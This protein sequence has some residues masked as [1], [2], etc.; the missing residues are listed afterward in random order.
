[1]TD[2]IAF[3]RV[4]DADGNDVS[5]DVLPPLSGSKVALLSRLGAMCQNNGVEWRNVDD[6]AVLAR[7][8]IDEAPDAWSAF[9]EKY[10]VLFFRGI[11]QFLNLGSF[12]ATLNAALQSGDKEL[13]A[14][15]RKLMA[16]IEKL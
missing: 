15:A 8:L 12:R 5:R 3:S 9:S 2:P 10:E 11:G 4:T 13:V 14:R 7:R 1:M 16:T 6:P